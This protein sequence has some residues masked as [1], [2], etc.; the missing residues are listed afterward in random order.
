MWIE[1]R[2]RQHRVYYRTGL[3]SPKKAFEPFATRDHADRFIALARISSLPKAIAYVRDPSPEALHE[4][5]GLRLATAATIAGPPQALA[6]DA[7]GA[8]GAGAPLGPHQVG[9]TFAELWDRFLQAQR[10]LEETT[11]ELYESYGTFHLL[12]FFGELDLGQIHR[13]R[14]LRLRDAV[15]GAVYVDDWVDAMLA[16]ERCNSAGRPMP[17]TSLSMKFIKNVL[18][19]LAQTFDVA[20][21][22]RPALLEVNPAREIR[23]PKQDR[24]EMHFLEDEKAYLALRC[25]MNA[26]FRPV[27]DFLVGTGARFGEAAGLLVR[28]VHLDGPRPYVEI[29]LVLKWFRKRYRLGRPK[30]RS[31]VRRITLSPRLVE[32]LRPLVET[33]GPDEHVFTMVEGGPLHHGNFT[34]RYFKPA[35][36]AAGKPVP[37]RLRI[38]DLRHTHAAWLISDGVPMFAVQRRLGHSSFATTSDVYGHLTPEAD[39]RTLALIDRRLPD[40]LARD[41]E[42]AEVVP[43]TKQ[44]KLLP[45]FDDVDDLD[46]LAA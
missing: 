25:A 15:A 42:G 34:N 17:G 4:L 24:R 27:L 40:V 12:P 33:R 6:T 28:H 36:K 5:L 8:A 46:D 22:A 21:Q 31:S 19:V 3:A 41:D 23:L 7:T 18:T 9:M 38:H 20:I 26:H 43:L 39:D 32:I 11:A 29:R 13:T 14:P 30:T 37:G 45:E 44:E 2:G 35:V 1:Q 16:K 10:Q